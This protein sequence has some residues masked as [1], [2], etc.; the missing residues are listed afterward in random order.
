MELEIL[1]KNL[2]K[3]FS[4]ET[5]N[6]ETGSRLFRLLRDKHAITSDQMK[7]AL[8]IFSVCNA[9]IHGNPVSLEEAIVIIDSAEALRNDYLS[10][11]GW[12]FSDGWEHSGNATANEHQAKQ[13]DSP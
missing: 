3:G 10:W 11:L 4:V 9:A 6:H 1:A 8:Q 2:A 7:L 13:A 5:T 12:G